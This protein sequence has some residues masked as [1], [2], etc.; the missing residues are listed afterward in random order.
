MVI[1]SKQRIGGDFVT[2]VVREEDN[3]Q[4]M[5]IGL[6]GFLDKKPDRNRPVWAGSS[7]VSDLFFFS[8]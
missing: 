8:F 4:K 3:A 5:H 6:S 1:G 2:A 7:S